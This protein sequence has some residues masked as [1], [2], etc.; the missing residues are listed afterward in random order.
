MPTKSEMSRATRRRLDALIEEATADCYDDDEQLMGFS[1]MLD[2]AV[3]VPFDAQVIGE[4]VIVTGFTEV[5]QGRGI[6]A[7]CH[8]GRKKYLIDVSSIEWVSPLPEGFE[9]V[10]A[11]LEW[12]RRH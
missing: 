2:E 5:D 11:Y 3:E 10:E 9:W 6:K 7:V 1:T 4:P 12:Q 8:R